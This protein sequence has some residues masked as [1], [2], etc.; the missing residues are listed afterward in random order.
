MK[1][2]SPLPK[3]RL[4]RQALRKQLRAQ[5][6]RRHQQWYLLSQLQ[7]SLQLLPP[8]WPVPPQPPLILPP[9]STAP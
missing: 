5:K 7:L 2:K 4:R 6:L 8:L 3:R 1:T 9:S